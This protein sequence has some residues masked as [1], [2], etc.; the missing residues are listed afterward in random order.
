LWCHA[1][2]SNKGWFCR[3]CLS[4]RLDEYVHHALPRCQAQGVHA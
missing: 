2:C 4:G 1:S 3:H